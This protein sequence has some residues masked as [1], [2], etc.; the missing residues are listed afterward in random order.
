VT[1]PLRRLAPCVVAL[2][3]ALALPAVASA[4]TTQ[5]QVYLTDADTSQAALTQEPSL[6]FSSRPLTRGV[7]VMDV[8]DHVQYQ[9]VLGFGAAM[10]DSSAFLIHDFLSAGSRKTVLDNLFGTSGKAIGLNFVRVPI[11]GSDFTADETPYTYDDLP[12]GQT[13]PN[14]LDFSVDH[15]LSYVIPTLQ[16]MMKVNPK[17][18]VISTQWTAP[19]WMKANDQPDNVG[20]LGT[21]L[22]ADYGVLARYI[23]KFVQDYDAA[24][25]PIWAV[26]P[27]NE[28]GAPAEYPGMNL[29]PANEATYIAQDL[30]PAFASAGLTARIYGGDTGAAEP[31][32]AQA[33][34]S[35]ADAAS[36]VSGEAWH[37]YGGQGGISAFHNRYTNVQELMTECS[38]GIIP[39]TG[40]EAAIDAMRNWASTATLWNVA[41]NPEGGPVEPPDQGCPN[42]SGLVTINEGLKT[43]LYTRNYYQLGQLSK[44]VE[45]GAVRI[46]TPRWVSDYRNSTGSHVTQGV[47]NVAFL[48]PDGSRVLT[49][50]NNTGESQTF[51]VSWDYK[52]FSYTLGA[53]AMV[54]F[55]WTG[56]EAKNPKN[57]VASC[58]N[59]GVKYVASGAKVIAEPDCTSK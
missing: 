50:Y 22:P 25:I 8:D 21:L 35:N 18:D 51:G 56:T 17:I 9:Q 45:R 42:C 59:S 36:A 44:Y 15:D 54:T 30:A 12:A 58:F 24:G 7:R 32:Y 26:T 2:V 33:T 27:E 49:A 53:G 47:D 57:D 4:Q 13:D 28:P 55:K 43:I 29:T 34:Q 37:C 16:Q 48:N 6:S 3:C 41:L 19:S 20:R 23:V 40:G 38:P 10:T 52:Q 46:E 5:V 11:G 31:S 39:Y 14:L 1:I